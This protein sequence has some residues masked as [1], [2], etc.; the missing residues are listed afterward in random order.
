M[1]SFD[2]VV[3]IIKKLYILLKKGQSFANNIPIFIAEKVGI[4]LS[5]LTVVTI[6]L[7]QFISIVVHLLHVF[8]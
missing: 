5:V 3:H 1:Y 6:L 4:R 8:G 2:F 7:T